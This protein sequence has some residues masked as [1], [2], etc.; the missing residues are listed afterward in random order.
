M[1]FHSGWRL[2]DKH[3]AGEPIP[4]RAAYSPR[5]TERTPRGLA[6]DS[7]S[8]NCESSARCSK[9]ER[10]D[11]HHRGIHWQADCG[12]ATSAGASDVTAETSVRLML[13]GEV[14]RTHSPDKKP[15]RSAGEI[16]RRRE[17]HFGIVE[18]MGDEG[19]ASLLPK[20]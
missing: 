15:S 13:R 9:A 11:D 8:A 14:Y 7:L 5:E 16:E 19:R 20:P 18:E 1:S 6:R 17:S 12:S 4:S 2:N 3:I 10:Q